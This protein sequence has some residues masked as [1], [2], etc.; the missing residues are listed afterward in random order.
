MVSATK[1]ATFKP[2]CDVPFPPGAPVNVFSKS[3]NNIG[4]GTVVDWNK[5]SDYKCNQPSFEF[6]VELATLVQQ[7]PRQY[8]S[9]TI[10]V[11]EA[12]LAFAHGCPVAVSCY[13]GKN[14][15]SLQCGTVVGFST[16]LYRG[17]TVIS[18]YRVALTDHETEHVHVCDEGTLCEHSATVSSSFV[19]DKKLRMVK[20]L[21][22]HVFYRHIPTPNPPMP[23]LPVKTAS[24][25]STSDTASVDT[26]LEV[27]YDSFPE[28]TCC[29]PSPITASVNKN[30]TAYSSQ[31]TDSSVPTKHNTVADIL[32]SLR[33][34]KLLFQKIANGSPKPES[35]NPPPIS[36]YTPSPQVKN[37]PVT[38]KKKGSFSAKEED[39]PSSQS[40][41]LSSHHNSVTTVEGTCGGEH[42]DDHLTVPE[43][44][45]VGKE[46]FTWPDTIEHVTTASWQELHDDVSPAPPC[47]CEICAASSEN[48]SFGTNTSASSK[49]NWE[50]A[51][52]PDNYFFL[53]EPFTWSTQGEDLESLVQGGDNDTLSPGANSISRRLRHTYLK[54]SEIDTRIRHNGKVIYDLEMLTY[55]HATCPNQKQVEIV[56]D[57][58]IILD[59]HVTSAL[60]SICST[61]STFSSLGS[62]E[63]DDSDW[64]P[65]SNGDDS[66]SCEDDSL[67]GI[68][69]DRD[70]SSS[71]AIKSAEPEV[72]LSNNKRHAVDSN[73]KRPPLKKRKVLQTSLSNFPDF[74]DDVKF[75]TRPFPFSQISNK[76]EHLYSLACSR[77]ELWNEN[78]EIPII[79]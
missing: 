3:M 31:M 1:T 5:E 51:T 70:H 20:C 28:D 15:R 35:L 32:L 19:H 52:V 18:Y 53:H 42:D 63:D 37:K 39:M 23:F 8:C 27:C 62:Y 13:E 36:K 46:P 73:R 75:P 71:V 4:F 58:S 55:H 33:H 78:T 26:K 29:K 50:D 40:P 38:M 54:P 76:K 45:F 7:R 74:P 47:Q 69:V 44:V 2:N 10:T 6:Q 22:K 66:S 56:F 25:R 60:T 34:D 59:G 48:A 21:P 79:F 68:V 24:T 43:E 41:E 65:P 11:G 16:A 64:I 67:M 77:H 9:N 49:D 12:Q 61:S 14:D 72:S 30:N 17:R 57:S